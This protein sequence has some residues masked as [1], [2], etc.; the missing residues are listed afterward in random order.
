MDSSTVGSREPGAGSRVFAD[1]ARRRA[2][3]CPSI[4]GRFGDS[5][6]VF[7]QLSGHPTRARFDARAKTARGWRPFKLRPYLHRNNRYVTHLAGGLKAFK[8]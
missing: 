1:C 8:T 3:E 5:K 2:Q 6:A 4:K 7:R